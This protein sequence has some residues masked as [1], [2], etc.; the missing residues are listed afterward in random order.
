M[1]TNKILHKEGFKQGVRLDKYL[2]KIKKKAFRY[3]SPVY[4]DMSEVEKF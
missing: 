4:F 1:W 3:G 2:D